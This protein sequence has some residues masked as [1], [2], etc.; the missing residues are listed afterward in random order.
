MT[1][2]QLANT[3]GITPQ[4]I[5]KY[6]VGDCRVF[7]SML[8][9]IAARLETTVAALVG[10]PGGA[11]VE[12]VILSQIALTGAAELLAAYASLDDG[13][14]RRDVLAMVHGAVRKS[15]EKRS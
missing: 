13:E 12:P 4:Q 14:V 2:R 3:L 5:Q 1:Q 8:I 6:E 9:K 11:Q 10:E 15:A 7:A